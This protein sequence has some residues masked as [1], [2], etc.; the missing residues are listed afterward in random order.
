MD[1]TVDRGRIVLDVALERLLVDQFAAD[2]VS[3]KLG[4]VCLEGLY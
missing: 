3:N 2:A 1:G 4:I